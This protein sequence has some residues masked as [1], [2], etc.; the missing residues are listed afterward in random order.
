MKT[1]I[2]QQAKITKEAK[3]F[4]QECVSEFISFVTSEAIKVCQQEKRKTLNGEGLLFAMDSLGFENYA[5]APKIYLQKYRDVITARGGGGTR[6]ALLTAPITSES[7]GL[8]PKTWSS[9]LKPVGGTMDKGFAPLPMESSAISPRHQEGIQTG[10]ADGN[11]RRR[12]G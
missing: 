7:C 6:G 10:G 3:G 12:R 1:A 5:E 9:D 11:F 2:P 8:D 4:M